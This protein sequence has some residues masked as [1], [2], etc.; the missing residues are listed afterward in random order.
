[1]ISWIQFQ[2]ITFLIILT[3]AN[4]FFQVTIAFQ[5]KILFQKR[6]VDSKIGRV[7]GP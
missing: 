1:M 3:Q 2:E 7:N 4:A 5:L 6:T